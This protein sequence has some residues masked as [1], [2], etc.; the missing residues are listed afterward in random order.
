MAT[1]NERLKALRKQKGDSQADLAKLIGVGKTSISGYE[2]NTSVP[3][4]KSLL[5]LINYFDVSAD[6]FLG[7]S[8][9]PTPNDNK[10]ADNLASK[11]DNSYDELDEI[12]KKEIQDFISF[13]ISRKNK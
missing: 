1:W 10:L 2:L 3:T 11:I 12:D 7:F 13:I 4:M 9:D 8:D 6:Y 5:T